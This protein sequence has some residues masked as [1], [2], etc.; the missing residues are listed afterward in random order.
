MKTKKYA[1]FQLVLKASI[2]DPTGGPLYKQ[3]LVGS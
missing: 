2:L 3:G 1:D